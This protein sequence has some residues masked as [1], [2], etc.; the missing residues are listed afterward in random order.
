MDF[1]RLARRFMRVRSR[2]LRLLAL[3]GAHVAGARY[4][5]VFLDPTT[6]CNLRCRMCYF[7]D[8]ERASAMLPARTMGAEA[9]EAV[10]ASLLP[11]ALKLQIG[12][13]AEP[14]VYARLP[15]LIALGR[16]AGVPYIEITTNGQLLDTPR[17]ERLVE[18]GL[19][20]M[21]LSLHGVIQATYEHLMQGATW[22][23]LQRLLQA[24]RHIRQS[25]PAFKLRVNYTFNNLNVTEL[26]GIF[27]L[28][29]GLRIDVLQI[30]P[31]QQIAQGSQWADYDLSAI[32]AD[33][34]AL[35]QPLREQARSLGTLCIAPEPR[36]LLAVD[37]QASGADA[38]IEEVTY[39]YVSPDSAYKPDFDPAADTFNSYWR[40]RH[41]MWRLVR[42]ALSPR[43][44]KRLVNTTKKL[45]YS[46]D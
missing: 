28:F 31:V 38:L 42:A 41:L 8:P 16:R 20:G 21:T 23:R 44:P 32:H 19:D 14:T 40:R 3:A 11:R 35:I 25:R 29:E 24:L 27:S 26:A 13:G 1:Y 33:Y 10:A 34:A 45:N 6:G 39:A 43:L 46:I 22:E 17:L 37:R 9:L 4:I 5:G 30:R 36:H 15:Q 2:R 12:C 7:S 18:A